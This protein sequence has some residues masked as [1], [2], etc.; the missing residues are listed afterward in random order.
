[1]RQT[2]RSQGGQLNA[3]RNPVMG[4]C[5]Y[6]LLDSGTRHS[7]AQGPSTCLF[8]HLTSSSLICRYF[9]WHSSKA[10]HH[11]TLTAIIHGGDLYKSRQSFC[12]SSWSPFFGMVFIRNR[13]PVHDIVLFAQVSTTWCQHRHSVLG[14][15]PVHGANT[16]GST[17]KI[18]LHGV[19]FSKWGLKTIVNV[20]EEFVAVRFSCV[21]KDEAK[22]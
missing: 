19:Q 18:S 10:F 17:H 6:G 15:W 14:R 11:P 2:D 13:I 22:Y 9:K 8:A 7:L 12:N 3:N 1:M 4:L 5:G 21:S 16:R 20:S